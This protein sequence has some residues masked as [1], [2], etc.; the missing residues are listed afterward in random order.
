MNIGFISTRIFG[1][2]GV[3]LE[4]SKIQNLLIQK[5]KKVFFMAG[6]LDPIFEKQENGYCFEKMHFLNSEIQSIQKTLFENKLETITTKQMQECW[7]KIDQF[8]N[9][10][11]Y[12]IEKFINKF[13]IHKIIT[14]NCLSIPMN[15]PLG[16]AIYN[17]LSKTGMECIN[18]NHDFYWERERF[19]NIKNQNLQDF[20]D[21]YFPPSIPNMK[22]LVINSISQETLLKRK[23]ISSVV[24]P[25]VFDFSQ[26]EKFIDEYNQDLR[27]S[28][29]LEKDDIFILQP[30]RIVPRKSIETSIEIVSRL[31]DKKAK[32]IITH[33]SSDEGDD[34]LAFLQQKAKELDVDM[35]IANSRFSETRGI[36]QNDQKIYSLWDAYL[37]A[38]IIL[39][40][41]L[42]EGFGNLVVEALFF[43][44][45]VVVNKYPVYL[46][47]IKPTGIKFIELENNQITDE[48]ISQIKEVLQSKKDPILKKKYDQIIQ[49]NFEI[50][51]QNFSFEILSEKLKEIGL[52]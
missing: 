30:T 24:V 33:S 18:H 5:A 47:D 11:E 25:N 9:E 37:F 34:Y 42:I 16:K 14:Q 44:K 6:E 45:M 15:L 3:S 4:I 51:I 39:Y 46:K 7:D 49:K 29:E 12:E 38:D 27:E 26:K 10:I 48:T 23:G 21:K 41:T 8:A 28:L 2:D 52:I 22:H 32:L 1:T 43:K 50:G 35:R 31:K 19:L 40:P 17:Y 20:L 13:N 36:N